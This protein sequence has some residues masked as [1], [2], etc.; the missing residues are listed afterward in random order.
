MSL[1]FHVI[2]CSNC[3][4]RANY[5]YGTNYKY[6]GPLDHEPLVERVWCGNCD[7]ATWA[8]FPFTQKDAEIMRH[9]LNRQIRRCKSGLFSTF[10]KSKRNAIRK[11]N[12][13]IETIN[14][15]LTYFNSTK[16]ETKC[17]NC[18][19]KSV[20]PINFPE[21]EYDELISLGI[22]HLCGGQLMI[23][24]AGRLIFAYITKVIYDENGNILVEERISDEDWPSFARK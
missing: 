6:E 21:S 2:S 24:K 9:V 3:E 16:F 17:L 15:R 11:A 20:F 19:G 14:Q 5:N 13:E 7:E 1:P 4:F 22:E 12:I 18:G 8:R 10:S 23:R